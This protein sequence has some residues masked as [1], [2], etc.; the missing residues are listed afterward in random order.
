MM[1]D[2]LLEILYLNQAAYK[3]SVK[4]VIAVTIYWDYL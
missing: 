4:N 2:S 3:I 1:S